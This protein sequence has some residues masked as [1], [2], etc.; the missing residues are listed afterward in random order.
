[1]FHSIAPTSCQITG[2][3]VTPD[4]FNPRGLPAWPRLRV[5]VMNISGESN[6]S[7]PHGNPQ[8]GKGRC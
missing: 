7:V 6:D 3:P 1:M 5:P 8:P 2:L 4:L